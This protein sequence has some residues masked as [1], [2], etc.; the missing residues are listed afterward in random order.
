MC[1]CM[2]ILEDLSR[3]GLLRFSISCWR[4]HVSFK[5]V[6]TVEWNKYLDSIGHG[7][8]YLKLSER[9]DL[10]SYY[11]NVHLKGGRERGFTFLLKTVT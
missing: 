5:S 9:N 2:Y 4:Y 8:I 10:L 6:E 7:T 11:T 3:P 1:V